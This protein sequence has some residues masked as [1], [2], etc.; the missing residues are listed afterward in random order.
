MVALLVP[1]GEMVFGF[2]NS[3]Y[4]HEINEMKRKIFQICFFE[5]ALCCVV[6]HGVHERS[7]FGFA[8]IYALKDLL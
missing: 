2:S 1:V 4:L 8:L 3:H 7:C 6:K 5:P